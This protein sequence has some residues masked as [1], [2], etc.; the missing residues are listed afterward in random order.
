MSESAGA[1]FAIAQV[2]VRVKVM[3]HNGGQVVTLVTHGT[4]DLCEAV[5]Q[6]GGQLERKQDEK[7]CKIRILLHMEVLYSGRGQITSKVQADCSA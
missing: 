7:T 1:V 4:P 3:L 2:Y 6:C 5:T